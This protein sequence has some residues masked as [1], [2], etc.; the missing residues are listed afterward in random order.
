MQLIE[1]LNQHSD[2]TVK[3]NNQSKL[4]KILETHQPPEAQPA[5]LL[6]QQPDTRIKEI[7]DRCREELLRLQQEKEKAV[8]EF[9]EAH[10][11]EKFQSMQEIK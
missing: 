10:A 5:A 8:E 1:E 3:L 2:L 6:P 7:M 4:C 9:L 11:E